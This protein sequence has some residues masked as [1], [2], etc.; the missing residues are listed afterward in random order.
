MPL[1]TRSMWIV[2]GL[3]ALLFLLYWAVFGT[4]ALKHLVA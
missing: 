4:E 2:L 1:F 3:L